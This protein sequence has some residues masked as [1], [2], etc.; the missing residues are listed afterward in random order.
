MF[1]SLDNEPELW[2]TTHLEIQGKSA[3]TAD[4]YIARTISLATALKKQFPDLV[5]FGPA[6]YGF[7]GMY[8][9]LGEM[10]ATP[11]WKQLVHR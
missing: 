10:N 2:K 6:H 3:V 5:I 11:S 8:N 1:V 9:W 7:M 4:S